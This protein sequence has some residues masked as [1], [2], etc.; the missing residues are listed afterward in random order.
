MVNINKLNELTQALGNPAKKDGVQKGTDGFQNALNNA[1][2]TRESTSELTGTSGL[3]E[4]VSTRPVIADPSGAV[5]G[6]T[7]DLLDLLDSYVQQLEN[8][9]VS[10]KALAPLIQ[11]INDQA[12]QLQEESQGLGADH[13]ELK[14]IADQTALAAQSEFM[15]FQRGDYLS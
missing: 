1:M 8:S 2:E 3:G 11:Q 15:R 14:T 7:G 12:Q 6:R 9:Q 10:L 4:L 5:S 13:S